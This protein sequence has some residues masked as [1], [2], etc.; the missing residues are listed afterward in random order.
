[1]IWGDM[2]GLGPEVPGS[3]LGF[4]KSWLSQNRFRIPM[5]NKGGS[6]LLHEYAGASRKS[7]YSTPWVTPSQR[8]S[9]PLSVNL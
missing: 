7:P 2:P 3:I 9:R 1:V 5:L 6:Y 4:S 8:L